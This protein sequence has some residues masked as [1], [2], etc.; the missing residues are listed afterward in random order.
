[1]LPATTGWESELLLLCC[2]DAHT[3]IS[4]SLRLQL[5]S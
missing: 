5:Q 4:G 3:V 2:R 1:M